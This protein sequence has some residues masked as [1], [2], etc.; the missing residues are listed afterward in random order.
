MIDPEMQVMALRNIGVDT[1]AGVDAVFRDAE[2]AAAA[3]PDFAIIAGPSSTHVPMS[4]FF[5]ERGVHVLIEKPI[6]SALDG[7]TELIDAAGAKGVILAVGYHLRFL[8]S[9][10]AAREAVEAGTIGRVVYIRAEVGQ[11]LPDWRPG[12]YRATVS[13]QAGLGGGV[14]LELSHEIDYVR[15]LVGEPL[16]VSAM[17]VR[18]GELDADAEDLAEMTLRMECGAT[19]SIHMDMLQRTPY[20][21]CRIVGSSGTVVWDA[22]AQTT[23]LQLSGGEVR[24]LYAAP[25]EFDRNQPYLDELG[26]FLDC[27]ERRATPLVTGEDGLRTL[28]IALAAKRAS[29]TRQ[30]VEVAP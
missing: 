1:P 19:A 9:L 29:M 28:K 24:T 13:A 25:A 30:T 20:R 14:V 17:I 23:T 15:W 2:S 10:Q 8:A 12:D 26:H 6:S 5:V 7:V 21:C 18:S 11:Y 4:R 22:L 27:I 16:E 3:K